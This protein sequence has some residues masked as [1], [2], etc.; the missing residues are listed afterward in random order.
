MLKEGIAINIIVKVTGLTEEEIKKI[1]NRKQVKNSCKK[2][3]I[4]V[5]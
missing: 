4:M 2:E 5:R 1:S 3:K